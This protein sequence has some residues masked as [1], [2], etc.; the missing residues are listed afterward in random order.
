MTAKN[1]NGKVVATVSYVLVVMGDTNCNGKVNTSDA[2]VTQ[3]IGMGNT[4]S[5]T[6]VKMAANV[7]LNGT[8][9][10][11]KINSSDVAYIMAKWFSWDLNTY[12]SNLK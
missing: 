5:S 12:V 1:S 6:A 11:P 10:D 8:L 7:N 3:N 4:G 2:V 9:D